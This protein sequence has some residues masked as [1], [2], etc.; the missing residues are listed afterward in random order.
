M[1]CCILFQVRN[2][3]YRKDKDLKMKNKNWAIS[4]IITNR[5]LIWTAKFSLVE[6]LI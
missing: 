6:Y 5:L 3:D 4:C 2:K 1:L